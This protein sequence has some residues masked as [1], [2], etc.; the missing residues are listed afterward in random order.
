MVTIDHMNTLIKRVLNNVCDQTT[1]G[2]LY[3]N[4]HYLFVSFVCG[5]CLADLLFYLFKRM[6]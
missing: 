5:K 6:T 1:Y 4:V 2:P 3:H